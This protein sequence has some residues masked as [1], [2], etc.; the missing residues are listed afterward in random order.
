MSAHMCKHV[1]KHM[2]KDVQASSFE[3]FKYVAQGLF[4]RHKL[5]FATQLALQILDKNGDLD[6]TAFQFL[7]R[8]TSKPGVD[9]PLSDWLADSAWDAVQVGSLGHPPP[10]RRSHPA[11][12]SAALSPSAPNL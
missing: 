6:A 2:P 10:L 7:I 9:N 12:S 4:E 3:V 8:G 5:I 1:R 11:R